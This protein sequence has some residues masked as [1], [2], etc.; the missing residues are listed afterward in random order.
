MKSKNDFKLHIRSERPCELRD[1]PAD[2]R[3]APEDWERITAKAVICRQTNVE[4][5]WKL[6]FKAIFPG[7][8][9]VPPPCKSFCLR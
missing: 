4:E 6:L 1:E 2:D 5:K 3:L 7:D 8:R 9:K